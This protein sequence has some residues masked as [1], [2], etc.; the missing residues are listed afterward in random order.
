MYN[1]FRFVLSTASVGTGWPFLSQHCGK[2]NFLELLCMRCEAF[3]GVLQVE[4]VIICY[5]N[6]CFTMKFTAFFLNKPL[7]SLMVAVKSLVKGYK[8]C[9]DMERKTVMIIWGKW[10][11]KRKQK[12]SISKWGSTLGC[13]LQSLVWQ[14]DCT[15]VW[16]VLLVCRLVV[17]CANLLKLYI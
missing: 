3:T 17:C 2:S 5:S 14:A 16:L 10:E 8:H 11:I 4:W 7:I 15:T 9:W 6:T 13:L 12:M 1:W